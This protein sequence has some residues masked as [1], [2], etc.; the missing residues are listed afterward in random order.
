MIPFS[1]VWSCPKCGAFAPQPDTERLWKPSYVCGHNPG[2]DEYLL[3]TCPECDY[4]ERMACQDV[5][6]A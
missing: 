2:M 5:V 1:R 3:W 4:M 6:S